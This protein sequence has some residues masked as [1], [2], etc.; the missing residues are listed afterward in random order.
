M[1]SR[2]FAL[3][4]A[5][6]LLTPSALASPVFAQDATPAATCAT[7]TEDQN[8][9]LVLAF[10]DAAKSGDEAAFGELLT[11]D[12]VYHELS[13]DVPLV[14]PESGAEAA[15]DWANERNDA[16]AT[17]DPILADGDLVSTW[18][19]WTGKDADTGADV[20]WN[21]AGLFRIECGK[22]AENWVV[23]DTLGRLM[24]SGS[25][26]ADELAGITAGEAPAP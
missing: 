13:V 15:A 4:V 20:T 7:T 9:E 8:K 14:T 25:I 24:T 12:H 23:A 21:S 3:I 5:G 11:P 2:G 6:L 18:M 22:I 26:T 10:F 19:T 17:V 16:T 1:P